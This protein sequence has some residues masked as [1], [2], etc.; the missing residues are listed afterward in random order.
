MIEDDKIRPVF[1]S[2]ILDMVVFSD[3][4]GLT[5]VASTK[6]RLYKWA[7]PVSDEDI[8]RYM[9]NCVD[10]EEFSPDEVIGINEYL[11]SWRDQWKILSERFGE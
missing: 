4:Y 1:Q 8:E 3:T 9:A 5:D 11:T 10:R 6:K 7:S 2:E